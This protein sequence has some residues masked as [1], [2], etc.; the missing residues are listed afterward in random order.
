MIRKDNEIKNK[1]RAADVVRLHV[2][3]SIK[4]K[5]PNTESKNYVLMHYNL[6]TQKCV[7]GSYRNA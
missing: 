4:T 3:N 1:T 7:R 6:C 2:P 5:S